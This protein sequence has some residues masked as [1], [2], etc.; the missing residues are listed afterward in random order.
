MT[1][2]RDKRKRYNPSRANFS[3]SI[4]FGLTS[5]V[6]VSCAQ[7]AAISSAD[8]T[9]DAANSVDSAVVEPVANTG[10]E[11]NSAIANSNK[12]R[13][14]PAAAV[15]STFEDSALIGVEKH[16]YYD[17][18]RDILIANGWT[19]QTNTTR[20]SAEYQT[21]GTIRDLVEKGFVEVT[22][23]SGTGPGYCNFQFTYTG[24]SHPEHN[25]RVLSMT[26]VASQAGANGEPTIWEWSISESTAIASSED[27][28]RT[29]S[30]SNPSFS[31]DAFEQLKQSESFCAG[32]AESCSY[33]EHTFDELT[34][35][36]TPNE[37]GGT[38]ITLRPTRRTSLETA[39]EY[40]AILD[41]F[42]NVDFAQPS[43]DRTDAN[44]NL[45][46]SYS[47]CPQMGEMG[48]GPSCF[49]DFTITNMGSVS[50]IRF[51]QTYAG[52]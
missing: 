19:P 41:A 30:R 32:L 43:T 7:P 24:R 39:K 47:G 17:Q 16:A 31:A 1:Y 11:A 36:A 18:T 8:A 21:D 23:C 37:I 45:V 51:V 35:T 40:A 22:A 28:N 20:G 48:L 9:A 33:S 10:S 12:S 3:L 26:T 49:I 27:I 46:K 15:T 34:L 2:L 14:T 50:E 5:L 29:S 44:Y 42:N 4:L 52:Q 38:I 25:G 6:A 13:T